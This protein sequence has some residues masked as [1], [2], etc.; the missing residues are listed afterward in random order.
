MVDMGFGGKSFAERLVNGEFTL[1]KRNNNL[2]NLISLFSKVQHLLK[3]IW[4][5]SCSHQV[6]RSLKN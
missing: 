3:V 4:N 5:Q 2:H 6:Q 1:E